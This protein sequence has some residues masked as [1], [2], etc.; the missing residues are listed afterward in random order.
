[1]KAEA[2][3][4]HAIRLVDDSDRLNCAGFFLLT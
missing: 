2:V 3:R 1:M 4:F